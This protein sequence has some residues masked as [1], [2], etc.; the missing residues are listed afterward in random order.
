LFKELTYVKG[1]IC[2]DEAQTV[3]KIYLDVTVS[4]NVILPRS[5]QLRQGRIPWAH[6][7]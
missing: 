3:N 1:F 2:L 6:I 4:I 7:V 5:S